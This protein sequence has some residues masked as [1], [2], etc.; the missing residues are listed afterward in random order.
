MIALVSGSLYKSGAFPFSC[1]GPCRY[2]GRAEAVAL[3]IQG[4][5]FG[6]SNFEECNVRVSDR[7][8]AI[9]LQ[10]DGSKRCWRLRTLKLAKRG[11]PSGIGFAVGIYVAPQFTIPRVLGSLA[12]QAWLHRA[13]SSHRRLMARPLFFR[14]LV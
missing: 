10:G 8:S 2:C 6:N 11:L 14:V 9:L 1:K 3:A 5:I 13:P 12:E 7:V 4:S